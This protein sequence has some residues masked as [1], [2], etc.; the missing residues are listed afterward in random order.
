[1][2]I[3]KTIL[4]IAYV[5]VAI[6]CT[7]LDDL[8]V[9]YDKNPKVDTKHYKNFS[10]LKK[11]KILTKNVDVD[12][13]MRL[14]IEDAIEN[15][16]IDKGYRFISDS[17]NADFVISYTIGSRARIEMNTYPTS[18]TKYFNWGTG[19][20]GQR[21][22]YGVT[23]VGTESEFDTY[24]EDKL[25]IDVYDVKS[26]QPAWHGWAVDKLNSNNTEQPDKVMSAFI[27]KVV[28]KFK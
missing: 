28:D 7:S 21:A 4:V 5:V 17:E 18:Y 19:Y 3:I 15:A 8:S 11:D 16:F 24:T 25:A 14:R 22:Y 13:V 2:F 12:P 6:G 1:M 27:V 23:T 26:R 20:Y 10:W 9:G